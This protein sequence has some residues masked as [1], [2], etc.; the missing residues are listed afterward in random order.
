MTLDAAG[1]AT[2][3]GMI[4]EYHW[5]T[6]AP[7]E[8]YP[9]SIQDL[10][11]RNEIGEHEGTLAITPR[12]SV[13]DLEDVTIRASTLERARLNFLHRLI[14]QVGDGVGMHITNQPD[15]RL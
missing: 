3:D 15:W 6:V 1:I 12:D 13:T 2:D 8:M 5:F 10:I 14:E 11:E 9:P 7:S 4:G